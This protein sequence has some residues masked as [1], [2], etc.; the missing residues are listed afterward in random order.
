MGES[1]LHFFSRADIVAKTALTRRGCC[2]KLS[3]NTNHAV[4]SPL[5]LPRTCFTRSL[6]IQRALSIEAMPR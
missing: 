5:P 3:L 4:G 6:S 1:R 2:I